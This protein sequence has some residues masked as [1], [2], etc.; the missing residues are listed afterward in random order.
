MST[1]ITNLLIFVP[2]GL[3]VVYSIYLVYWLLKK[4]QG[5][6]EMVSISKAIQE[7][8]TAYLNRQY[9]TVAIV[10]VILAVIIGLTLGWVTAGA[11][12]VGGLASAITGYIGMNVAVR[13]N[14]RLKCLIDGVT[15]ATKAASRRR[16][17]ALAERR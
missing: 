4:P 7:G 8:S 16:R 14:S 9:K 17:C 10:S 6:K 1:L 11:F 15:M 3:A 13:A 2:V 5:D 12:I